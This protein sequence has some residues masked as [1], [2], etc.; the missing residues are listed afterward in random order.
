M[1]TS[2]GQAEKNEDTGRAPKSRWS[3]EGTTQT[4]P[5]ARAHGFQRTNGNYRH[6]SATVKE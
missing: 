3:E 2:L 1:Y 5:F 4:F 6:L